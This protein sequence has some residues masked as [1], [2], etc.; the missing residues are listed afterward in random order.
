MATSASPTVNAAPLEVELLE[1][2]VVDPSL[3]VKLLYFGS[4]EV[5]CSQSPP[6]KLFGSP[7]V[8]GVS[9]VVFAYHLQVDEIIIDCVGELATDR[10]P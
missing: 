8:F 7:E 9:L 2:L 10:R 5:G 6:D 1:H 3:E 4:Y